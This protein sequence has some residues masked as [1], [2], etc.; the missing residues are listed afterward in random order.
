MSRASLS[1]TSLVLGAAVLSG[2]CASMLDARPGE[3]TM[4][5]AIPAAGS[6]KSQYGGRDDVFGIIAAV[7][8]AGQVQMMGSRAL[9][10]PTLPLQAITS[11]VY[12]YA[13]SCGGYEF[14]VLETAGTQILEYAYVRENGSMY[15][16][17]DYVAGPSPFMQPGLWSSYDHTS[18][19]ITMMMSEFAESST[20]LFAATYSLGPITGLAAT[21]QQEFG[22]AYGEALR[23]ANGCAERPALSSQS[24]AHSD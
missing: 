1:A 4:R 7:K 11:F 18:D 24:I 20:R 17:R 8:S 5:A 19:G 3:Q 9:R 12:R 15:L 21:T 10:L 23:R 16:I 13:D 2:G 22:E 14:R 6:V